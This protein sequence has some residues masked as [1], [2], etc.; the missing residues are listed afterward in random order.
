MFL[1][2][3]VPPAANSAAV[4][5]ALIGTGGTLATV[6]IT[7]LLTARKQNEMVHTQ[8]EVVHKQVEAAVEQGVQAGA[9]QEVHTLTN[10]RLERMDAALK[11]MRLEAEK[12]RAE[13][14]SL[15]RLLATA[16]REPKTRVKARVK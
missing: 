8:E 5:I 11:A 10:D 14:R 1:Q 13:I 9:I 7:H 12:D 3:A 4:W 2:E 15:K 6:V 16:R